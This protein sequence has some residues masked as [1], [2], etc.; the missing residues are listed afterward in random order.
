MKE[1][2]YKS[3]ALERGIRVLKIIGNSNFTL[4]QLT[5]GTKIPVT[6][7]L[8]ILTSLEDL[9]MVTRNPNDKTYSATWMLLPKNPSDEYRKIISDSLRELTGLTNAIS[10]WYFLYQNNVV[11]GDR[12]SPEDGPNIF[13]KPG[14]TRNLWEEFEAVTQVAL[15]EIGESYTGLWHWEGGKQTATNAKHFK[16]S[17]KHLTAYNCAIDFGKNNAGIKRIATRVQDDLGN[18]IGII[19]IAYE[20]KECEDNNVPFK[21]KVLTQIAELLELKIKKIKER[22]ND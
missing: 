10:E 19:A 8:R 5:K 11:L 15:N 18:F 20:E 14:F 7:L 2:V 3:I 13:A 21:I 16:A 9:G 6:S 12:Y 1:K 4:S 17:Q 22:E